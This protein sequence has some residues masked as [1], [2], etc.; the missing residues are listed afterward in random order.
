MTEEPIGQVL[1]NFAR[2]IIQQA[3]EDNIA[4]AEK[5]RVFSQITT[6]FV[7]IHKVNAAKIETP[8]KTFG[9]MKKE[10]MENEDGSI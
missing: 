7:G 8:A 2:E 5:L 3:Q 9:G 10:L 6:Y 4:L 1:E